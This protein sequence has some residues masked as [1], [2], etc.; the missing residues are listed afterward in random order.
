MNKELEN[1]VEEARDW[2]NRAR[3]AW[4]SNSAPTDVV[5]FYNKALDLYPEISLSYIGYHE[6]CVDLEDEFRTLLKEFQLLLPQV[7][8]SETDTEEGLK[9]INSFWPEDTY[10]RYIYDYAEDNATKTCFEQIFSYFE[11]R[12]EWNN[13]LKCISRGAQYAIIMLPKG[14]LDWLIN[15]TDR[16]SNMVEN[17]Q[18][19]QDLKFTVRSFRAE[20]EIIQSQ[21]KA[22]KQILQELLDDLK[23]ANYPPAT[24]ATI[25]PK[26]AKCQINLREYDLAAE[27]IKAGFQEL[28]RIS[29]SEGRLGARVLYSLKI[30]SYKKD[31]ETEQFRLLRNKHLV[32]HSKSEYTKKVEVLDQNL[33]L[34]L[35]L[36]KDELRK[37]NI[38][39]LDSVKAQEFS[40]HF[41]AGYDIGVRV[42]DYVTITS[43]DK[44]ILGQVED[45]KEVSTQLNYLGTLLCELSNEAFLPIINDL[46]VPCFF[47][48]AQ[49]ELSSPWVLRQYISEPNPKNT[50]LVVGDFSQVYMKSPIKVILNHKGFEQH[51]A[52]FGQSGSGK[53]FALGRL[54]EELLMNTEVRIVLLDPNSDYRNIWHVE[55]KDVVLKIWKDITGRAFDSL[56]DQE[57]M[58]EAESDYESYNIWINLNRHLISVLAD[59]KFAAMHANDDVRPIKLRLSEVDITYQVHLLHLDPQFHADECHVYRELLEELS[60]SEYS[61]DKII[62]LAKSRVSHPLV[63]RLLSRLHNADL[64]SLEIFKPVTGVVLPS[65]I[66]EL[67]RD[68]WRLLELDIG[69][70]K[71]IEKHLVSFAILDALWRQREKCLERP[72]LVIIDEAHH[73]VPGDPKFT[74]SKATAD[75]INEIA[76]EG[77]K[78][79]IF[80]MV[81]SQSPSK[82]HP[83]TLSQCNNLILLKMRHEA[84]LAVVRDAFSQV[85]K[86]MIDKAKNFK[87]GESLVIGD[88]LVKSPIHFRFGVRRSKEG[89]TKARIPALS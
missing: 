15:E 34:S 77:R 75:I 47:Q 36:A 1:Q 30:H 71:P 63:P 19:A 79:G 23:S 55:E 49:V 32:A 31:V 81:V 28:D 41:T 11:S 74:Q 16:V 62:G 38:L 83:F 84:D 86:R 26:I 44:K 61:V 24:I 53:S 88:N 21:Y 87:V 48:D 78:Y 8:N 5:S 51:T 57:I 67:K 10:S 60:G 22:A 12:K 70:F 6:E 3:N 45:L 29:D 42:G 50:K 69:E 52:M 2:A 37:I 65:V 59:S 82:L 76:G 46:S 89:R 20:K 72:T 25:W 4:G 7:L 85:P 40:F 18:L 68:R 80:L 39:K 13:L 35:D 66:D 64:T 58:L 27:S 9:I 14:L 43:S 33:S 73:L 54:V 17:N 56:E